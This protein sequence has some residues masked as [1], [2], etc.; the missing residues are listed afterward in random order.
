MPDT[1]ANP[2]RARIAALDPARYHRHFIHGEGRTWAETN[3]YTDVMIEI[4]HGLGHEP[5]ACLAFTLAVDFE[6]DQWTFF[7]PP[8]ADLYEL[9]GWD[10][11]E[12][13]IWRPLHE[14]VAGLIETG[15]LPLLELDSYY[16]P[17]T[18]GTAFATQTGAAGTALGSTF[19]TPNLGTGTQSFSYDFNLDT[20]SQQPPGA[21]MFMRTDILQQGSR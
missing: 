7:K 14:H 6:G 15:K 1:M 19:R 8:H 5:A 18:A 4:L 10:I 12:L 3:C 13:S 2:G 20:P 9:Y 11:Q 16:L 17:D 21:P